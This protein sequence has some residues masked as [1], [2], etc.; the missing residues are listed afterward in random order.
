[1]KTLACSL[2]EKKDKELIDFIEEQ[3]RI[4]FNN[5]T[6]LRVALYSY[7]KAS[8]STTNNMINILNDNK[9]NEA[10]EG[11]TKDIN[12]NDNVE[13][14][15]S[16]QENKNSNE[17]HILIKEEVKEE[18]IEETKEE[19]IEEEENSK[20]TKDIKNTKEDEQYS[21]T[22]ETDNNSKEDEQDL[23]EAEKMFLSK[24]RVSAK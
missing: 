14:K 1:M 7:M 5:S 4:G 9:S 15:I 18:A 12:D 3:N 8:K 2:N 17:A 20:D 19:V 11:N 13:S 23:S 24:F 16:I 6:L 21:H 22:L 10:P